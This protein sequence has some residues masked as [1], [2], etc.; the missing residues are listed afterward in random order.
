MSRLS[1]SLSLA[2]SRCEK[3]ILYCV[4][5]H[6]LYEL[7]E[8]MS[9]MVTLPFSNRVCVCVCVGAIGQAEPWS[10]HLPLNKPTNH[11]TQKRRAHDN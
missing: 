3:Y 11:V 1:L 8:P 6:A 9:S 2:I 4:C 7:A 10:M 5:T